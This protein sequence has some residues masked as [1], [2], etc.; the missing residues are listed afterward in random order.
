LQHGVA[1]GVADVDRLEVGTARRLWHDAQRLADRLQRILA[2]R[3]ELDQ[4]RLEVA[5]P[6][7]EIDRSRHAAVADRVRRARIGIAC[8]GN[9]LDGCELTLGWL[10]VVKSVAPLER[11]FARLHDPC[12]FDGRHLRLGADVVQHHE[13]DVFAVL[14]LGARLAVLEAVHD[15]SASVDVPRFAV[16]DL[17]F[18]RQERRE[19]RL[20]HAIAVI[21]HLAVDQRR[22]L[23]QQ[24]GCL[25]LHVA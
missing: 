10:I 6:L 19:G 5:A 24:Q 13:Q 18:L 4:P 20:R 17:G 14:T 15:E 25:A 22:L 3:M 2:L 9:R 16:L 1:T 8:V 12:R 21:D 11:P 7:F 23:A